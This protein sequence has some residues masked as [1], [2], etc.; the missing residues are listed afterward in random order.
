MYSLLGKVLTVFVFPP[1]LQIATVGLALVLL[2]RRPVLARSLL[3]VACLSLYILSTG[4]GIDLLLAPLESTYPA[5]EPDKASNADAIVVLGDFVHKPTPRRLR[6]EVSDNTDRLRTGGLLYR[7]GKAPFILLTGGPPASS[8][9]PTLDQ[10]VPA[11]VLLREMG[12]PASA[13]LSETASDNTHENAAFS[14]PLLRARHANRILLVTSAFHMRRAVA[15]FRKEGF[16]VQ[17]VPA[18]F[19]TGWSDNSYPD[20]FLPAARTMYQNELALHEY[21]GLWVYRFRGWA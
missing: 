21:L 3:L 2:R 17:A 16:D 11:T 12:I 13:I 8:E 7:A 20:Y 10:A 18:D 4:L 15:I 14:A 1:G 5:V 19:H 6:F 9:H